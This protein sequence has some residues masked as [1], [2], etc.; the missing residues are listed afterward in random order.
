DEPRFAGRDGRRRLPARA[1]LV[2]RQVGGLERETSERAG[3][4]APRAPLGAAEERSEDGAA[5]HRLGERHDAASASTT[6]QP[7]RCQAGTPSRGTRTVPSG[8]GLPGRARRPAGGRTRTD[9]VTASGRLRAIVN[10]RP[11]SRPDGRRGQRRPDSAAG[12]D[13]GAGSATTAA[14]WK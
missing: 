3:E 1:L 9:S 11:L 14:R 8:A 12:E 4:D 13:D 6:C 5:L 10:A 2:E 7:S